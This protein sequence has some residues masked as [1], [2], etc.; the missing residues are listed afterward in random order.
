MKVKRYNSYKY[1]FICCLSLHTGAWTI[2]VQGIHQRL[3][4]LVPHSTDSDPFLMSPAFFEKS[5]GGG[6]ASTFP[7]WLTRTQHPSPGLHLLCAYRQVVN[8][9]FSLISSI[10]IPRHLPG[11]VPSEMFGFD[12]VHVHFL[13][14]AQQYN[15]W[16]MIGIHARNALCFATSMN[17]CFH[18]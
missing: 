13:F 11:C 2:A 5:G 18:L 15:L 4:T 17:Y 14:I 3:L 1:S 6:C 12:Q 16:R 10:K 7:S 8:P 9:T